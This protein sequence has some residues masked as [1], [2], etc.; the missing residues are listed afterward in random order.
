MGGWWETSAPSHWT[1]AL[2]CLCILT[3]RQL[4]SPEW[5]VQGS[6][7]KASFFDG[8][9]PLVTHRHST[10]SSWFPWEETMQE[11]SV[12]G[13]SW[14]WP[15]TTECTY[16]LHQP[17]P[18]WPHIFPSPLPP[19]SLSP[20]FLWLQRPSLFCLCLL[21]SLFPLRRRLLP[22]TRAPWCTSFRSSLK[23]Y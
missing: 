18:V 13:A 3:T 21:Y 19:P 6:K 9:T 5:V 14:R 17:Y 12:I 15:T 20:T 16:K 22:K 1:L 7:A 8:P 2:I 23:C 4:A 10:I 11:G